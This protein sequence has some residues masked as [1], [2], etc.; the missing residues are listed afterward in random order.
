MVDDSILPPS[1]IS[2]LSLLFG[3]ELDKIL[4]LEPVIDVLAEPSLIGVIGLYKLLGDFSG[5]VVFF[6]PLY[7]SRLFTGSPLC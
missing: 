7:S 4:I 6:N 2:E 5:V 1:F 3:S